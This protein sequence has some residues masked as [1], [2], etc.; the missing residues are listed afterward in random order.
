MLGFALGGALM[1]TYAPYATSIGEV[2]RHYLDN[3]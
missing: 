2:I 3:R 1:Q